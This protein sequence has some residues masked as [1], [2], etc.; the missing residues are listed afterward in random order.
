M[1]PKRELFRESPL[2]LVA[3]EIRFTDSARIRRQETIDTIS[4][5]LEDWLPFAHSIHEI[6][7]Q[8]LPGSTPAASPVATA[9]PA[10]TALVLT[11]TTSSESL[12]LAAS[13]MVYESTDYTEFSVLLAAVERATAALIAAGVRPALKRIGLRYIDEVRV[14]DLIVDIRQWSEWIDHRLIDHLDIGPAHHLAQVTQGVTT[15]NLDGGR[16]LNFRFAALNQGPVVAPKILH[17]RIPVESGPFFVL[18]FDGYQEFSDAIA[19]PLDPAVISTSLS[20]VHAPAG[21]AFQNSITDKSRAL[22]RGVQR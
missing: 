16:R 22:F 17:R 6:G 5:A 11:N 10:T 7:F 4:T 1:Y 3:V 9:M 12:T 2:A 8:V 14:P 18:D 21:E 19:V 13:S 15:Y 20:A